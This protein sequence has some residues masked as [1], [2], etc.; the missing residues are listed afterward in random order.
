MDD[1]E[2]C[3]CGSHDHDE[4]CG[5]GNH[6]HH[7]GDCDCEQDTLL[8]TLDDDTEVECNVIGIFE[9]GDKEYI[10]LLPL[11]DETVLLYQYEDTD[12]NVNLSSIEDDDEFKA[13]TDAF[14]ELYNDDG[15]FAV[16]E[17]EE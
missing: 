7:D 8:I 17:E 2:K 10:A 6:H 15:D 5:C 11:D 14:F 12:D 3:G 16:D 13:V 4:E 9:V 1:K